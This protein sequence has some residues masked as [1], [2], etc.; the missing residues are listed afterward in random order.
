MDTGDYAD[1][2]IFSDTRA[3]TE[4]RVG[5]IRENGG[6]RN[7]VEEMKDKGEGVSHMGDEEDRDV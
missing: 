1:A 4:K 7:A 3:D 2:D 6:N 5:D